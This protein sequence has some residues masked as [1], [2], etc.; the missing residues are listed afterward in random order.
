M[1]TYIFI[2]ALFNILGVIL[3]FIYKIIKRKRKEERE[4]FK[5]EDE[6][7]LK[8]LQTLHKNLLNET[9]SVKRIEIMKKI[10]LISSIYN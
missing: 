5:K 8:D 10:E 3:Y 2:V 6:K 9:D 7:L 4:Y 1:K